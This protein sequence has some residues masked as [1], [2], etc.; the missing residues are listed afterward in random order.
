MIENRS[1]F[2]IMTHTYHRLFSLNISSIYFSTTYGYLISYQCQE[3]GSLFALF[4]T[5]LKIC[6]F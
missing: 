6:E 4:A 5:D 1:R 3:Y 2:L